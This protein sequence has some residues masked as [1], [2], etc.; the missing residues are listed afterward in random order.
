MNPEK[1]LKFALVR[2]RPDSARQEI[3]NIGTVVFTTDGPLITITGNLLKL[4][5]IDPN[6][7]LLRVHEESAILGRALTAL[8]QNGTSVESMVQLL[9]KS[10]SGITLSFLGMINTDG[11]DVSDVIS[12][13]QRDLVLPPIEKKSKKIPRISRLH[14][15]LRAIFKNAKMLGSNPDDIDNHLVVLNYP[16]DVDVGLYAEFALQNGKLHITETV[17]FRGGEHAVKKRE[18]ESKTLLLVRALE[19]VG[20]SDL[21]RH[22]VVSGATAATQASINLL[23]RYADDLIVRESTEDWDRYVSAMARAA[24][25]DPGMR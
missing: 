15:E 9:G 14:T 22:V 16:I 11:R 21:L 13:L 12:E 24:R 18:A 17:D 4:L 6:L 8:W 1:T 10:M 20:K 19:R 23:S 2:Y 3:V 25:V 5:A 7:S